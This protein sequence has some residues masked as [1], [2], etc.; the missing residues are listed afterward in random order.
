MSTPAT[1]DSRKI[2]LLYDLGT[3]AENIQ[4]S[5]RHREGLPTGLRERNVFFKGFIDALMAH[6]SWG[7]LIALVHNRPSMQAFQQLAKA[8][9]PVQAGRRRCNTITE[10]TIATSFFPRPPAPLLHGPG[11]PDLRF[12]WARQ[13][14][15]T[16]AFSMCGV[17]FDSVSHP[18]TVQALGQLLTSPFEAHDALICTSQA[19]LR[20][21]KAIVGAWTDF[22]RERMGGQPASRMRLEHIPPG[23]PIDVF[24]PVPEEQRQAQRKALKIAPDEMAVLWTGQ[25]SMHLRGHP[26][27]LFA[28]MSEAARRTGKK[29]VLL[30][31]GWAT[32]EPILKVVADAFRI[33]APNIRLALVDAMAPANRHA[34]WQAAD[35]YAALDDGVHD[36]SNVWVLQAMAS[37][38]PVVASD[39]NACRDIVVDGA[40]GLL[41]PT[42]QV[43]DATGDSV[44]RLILG[45]LTYDLFL[46]EY[47]QTVAVDIPAASAAF[48][49]LFADPALRQ[50]LGA[51]GRQRVLD[52]YAWPRIIKSYEALWDAL[53]TE[54]QAFLGRA[55][56]GKPLPAP[57]SYPLPDQLFASYPT[58]LLSDG[59][60]IQASP[61][62]ETRILKLQ[63]MPV[64]SFAERHRNRDYGLLRTLLTAAAAP[65]TVGQLDQ[66]FHQR[67]IN[68]TLGRSTLGWML[69]YGLLNVVRPTTPAPG[70]AS[71]VSAGTNQPGAMPASVPA[72]TGI[73]ETS[74]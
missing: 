61:D 37:G 66:Q 1:P 24:R 32:Q 59:D 12:A 33:F 60:L 74:S 28:G 47:T 41:V 58:G 4:R 46:A 67:G 45:E 42:W 71:T 36:S 27:P 10:Q 35:I 73:P 20:F 49:R 18:G 34:I 51:A 22:L 29:T 5:Q 26:F 16:G 43:R 56:D 52:H 9:P 68:R 38:L 25:V 69:K 63:G 54:R 62:A 70:A 8:C 15:G 17:L 30:L 39:W 31:A 50:R 64:T 53:E 13:T 21:V 40:T 2:A 6:G 55:G 72:P 44:L 19:Q 3:H 48:T 57:V 14:A 11:V 7:E 23:V 65:C